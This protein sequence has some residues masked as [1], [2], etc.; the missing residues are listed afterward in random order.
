MVST[1][2]L[3]LNRVVTPVFRGLG[4]GS[5]VYEASNEMVSRS[6]FSQW[7]RARPNPEESQHLATTVCAL[8]AGMKPSRSLGAAVCIPSTRCLG[9]TT[10]SS[11]PLI[12]HWRRVILGLL[13]VVLSMQ[14]GV[15]LKQ[16]FPSLVLPQ[17]G[18]TKSIKE[19]KDMKSQ[20][21][22]SI[23]KQRVPVLKNGG[24]EV[25]VYD[26]YANVEEVTEMWVCL[27]SSVLK[28]ASVEVLPDAVQL[29]IVHTMV[30][31]VSDLLYA[32][33][34]HRLVVTAK[35]VPQT[36]APHLL[37]TEQTSFTLSGKTLSTTLARI[38]LPILFNALEKSSVE[39]RSCGGPQMAMA[40]LCDILLGGQAG[41]RLFP[42]CKAVLVKALGGGDVALLRVAVFRL[43]PV[44][45]GATAAANI[46]ACVQGD[47]EVLG[48]VPVLALA[49]FGCLQQNVSAGLT[50]EKK[51]RECAVRCA[52]AG[53]LNV[54]ASVCERR[55]GDA[56]IW[57]QDWTPEGLVATAVNGILPQSYSELRGV[58][59]TA[60]RVAL[61]GSQPYEAR[62]IAMKGLGSVAFTLLRTTEGGN[63][64]Q[65]SLINTAA[66][67]LLD[68]N[69]SVGLEAT[70][71][72]ST[73]LEGRVRC[74]EGAGDVAE[75]LA[76]LFASSLLTALASHN[77][78]NHPALLEALVH[79]LHSACLPHQLSNSTLRLAL[80]ALVYAASGHMDSRYSVMTL[81]SAR[82]EVARAVL[83]ESSSELQGRIIVPSE[84]VWWEDAQGVGHVRQAAE[85]ALHHLAVHYARHDCTA[86]H[87]RCSSSLEEGDN[88]PHLMLGDRAL[89]SLRSI[90]SEV[91]L[92]SRSLAGR[93]TWS[94]HSVDKGD[95]SI[96]ETTNALVGDST[97][98][99]GR[100]RTHALH[101]S[102][103]I[104]SAVAVQNL[105]LKLASQK[106]SPEI[107]EKTA[108]E[109]P[110]LSELA[111]EMSG[112][113]A[114]LEEHEAE[115][116]EGGEG[117][118]KEGG[119]EVRGGGG[120]LRH[121]LT[122]FP[123]LSIGGHTQGGAVLRQKATQL[124]T[125]LHRLDSLPDRD[126]YAVTVLLATT[127]SPTLE[128]VCH[129]LC[130]SLG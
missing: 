72:L 29:T 123:L 41:L 22:L 79:A 122:T 14:I 107:P 101:E 21:V 108:S 66:M 129:S 55:G 126:T 112:V 36:S 42:V 19:A 128:E 127:L 114:L 97:Q 88:E 11:N 80:D 89:I 82:K 45:R 8:L 81:T 69:C 90:Q 57:P 85:A 76:G 124:D 1:L 2:R 58:V 3:F 115:R 46:F 94:L 31:V 53:L 39:F 117:V 99:T 102:H 106:H 78:F 37:Q 47:T 23:H 38:A 77:L 15:E 4:A 59:V 7:V 84:G 54:A 50:P 87:P 27:L 86:T 71:A 83:A 48:I 109:E 113:E 105:G 70:S 73:L 43:F 30:D 33:Q 12:L 18:G 130:I 111:K 125:A 61:S 10:F 119:V 16:P 20:S 64:L 62:C 110:W 49:A 24:V 26:Q 13:R 56:I 63:A 60:L 95:D 6:F 28:A 100:G 40:G 116:S 17:S 96:F 65:T 98:Q 91:H 51:E 44:V 52:A 121:A 35:P 68:A 118:G 74:L 67:R 5:P 92:T 32:Q 9:D 104:Q 34:C 120:G 25:L 103:S 93:Y 75:T